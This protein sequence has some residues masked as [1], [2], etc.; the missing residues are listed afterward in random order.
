MKRNIHSGLV[1]SILFVLISGAC[2]SKPLP[3]E[4]KATESTPSLVLPSEELNF[5]Q[6][7]AISPPAPKNLRINPEGSSVQIAWDAADLVVTPHGYSDE[8]LFYKIFRREEGQLDAIQLGTSTETSFLDVK[9]SAG[10]NY[11]YSVVEV[12]KGLEGGEM[13][14]SRSEEVELGG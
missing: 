6:Q 7:Q 3:P 5:E 4:N 10:V 13:D 1:I 8:V 9:I 11:F 2:T 12:H 14:G